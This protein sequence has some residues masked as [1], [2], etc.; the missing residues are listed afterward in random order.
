MYANYAL[1]KLCKRKCINILLLF[2]NALDS[3]K[4]LIDNFKTSHSY[5]IKI[6]CFENHLITKQLTIAKNSFINFNSL[7]F[8]RL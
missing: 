8:Q 2:S 6:S 7:K 5:L 4:K 1:N 3:I